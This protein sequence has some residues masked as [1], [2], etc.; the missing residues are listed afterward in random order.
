MRPLRSTD[1]TPLP[2]YYQPLRHPLAF[3]PLPGATGYKVYL[4]PGISAWGEEGFS[5][6]LAC[7][8][9][10]AVATTPPES[11]AATASMRQ[12]L[13]PSPYGCQ[14][15]LRGFA[16]SGPPVHSLSLRPGDSLPSQGWLCR[17]ASGRRF[18]SSLPSKLR[19]FWL[20]PRWDCLPLNTPAF[21][22]RTT[23]RAVLP[24][25]ALGPSSSSRL[26]QFQKHT[27]IHKTNRLVKVVRG[28]SAFPARAQPVLMNLAWPS[29]IASVAAPG[30]RGALLD[31]SSIATF[32]CC[33]VCTLEPGPLPSTG[34]TRLHRYCGP[35]RHPSSA[36]RQ[37][38]LVTEP[39]SSHLRRASRVSRCSL[40]TCRHPP[41]RRSG[42]NPSSRSLD[43]CQPSPSPR[44]VGLRIVHSGAVSVFTH[45]TACQLADGL[46]PPLFSQASTTS[47]PP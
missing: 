45:V 23:A 36:R 32:P 20:L 39:I 24:H 42:S 4:P 17:W 29:G 16:L 6:C 25:T 14:L 5:S 28:V 2:R 27:G 1:V 37:M 46:T 26:A 44:R 35:L 13:L 34:I 18:P 33:F 8:C 47:L 21:A 38:R 11:P 7:P 19:G 9:H 30:L 10:H 31:S 22:G 40:L 41:P 12:A 3:D 43:P 15:G